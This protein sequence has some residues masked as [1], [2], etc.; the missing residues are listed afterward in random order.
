MALDRHALGGEARLFALALAATGALALAPV[1]AAAGEGAPAPAAEEPPP[2]TLDEVVVRVPRAEVAADPTAAASVVEARRFAGEAK[3]VAELVSTA[4]GVA[5]NEYGGLGHL[6]TVSIRGSNSDGVKVLLD[7]LPLS[8]A[9]GGGFDLSTV[10]RQWLSRVEVVRGAEGARYGAGALGG[11]VNLVTRPAAAGSWSSE[12]SWGSFSTGAASADVAL[13]GEGWG[14]LVAATAQGSKGDFTWLFAERP[15]VPGSARIERTRTHDD[16]ASGG[17]LAKGWLDAAGGRFDWLAQLSGG[18]RDLPGFPYQ[19]TPRDWEHDLRAA[20]LVR[21][22]RE[23]GDGLVLSSGLSGRLDRTDTLAAMTRPDPFRQR[24]LDGEAWLGATLTRGARVTDAELRAGVERLS[25]D[26]EGDARARPRA[27]VALSH[28]A[29]V[30]DGRLRLTAA[31][32]AEA[33][34]Q[35]RGLSGKLGASLAIAGPLSVRASAGRTFRAPSFAELFLQQGILQPNPG[36]ASETSFTADAALVADGRLGLA[37]LGAF[38]ALYDDLIVYQPAS[39]GRLKPFN[40]GK[41][42]AAGLEAEVASAPVGPLGLSA[43]A[44]YT[45]Q[46][47]ETLR[48]EAAELGRD[49]PHRP[50]HRVY[51]RLAVAPGPFGGHVELHHVSSQYQDSRNLLAVPAATTL[52]AGA[53][54]RLLSRPDVRAGVEVKNLLDDRTLTD[55]F[56]NPLPGRMILLVLRAGSTTPGAP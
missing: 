31:G 34:G 42:S 5:V 10:P 29:A 36:L 49:V 32:R 39:Q 3:E 18:E 35:Y 11:V 4:P 38:G 56:G 23:L 9:A 24:D 40:D 33:Q 50:R 51:A 25:S 46:V 47:T 26:G 15:T 30:A 21:H 2:V 27:A 19:L 6:S 37:S 17:A 1:P 43:A 14:A 20:L 7:G 52:N 16:V 8:G 28:E 22:A 41:A 55:P 45:Y 12:L 44:A 13:G 53:S 48:G 54:L